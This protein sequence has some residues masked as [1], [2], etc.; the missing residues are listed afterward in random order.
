MTKQLM[1]NIDGAVYQYIT[2]LSKQE[3]VTKRK[4]LEDAITHYRRF[5]E[6]KKLDEAYKDMSQDEE[7]LKEMEDTA[8]Y[9]AH[10]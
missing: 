10:L 5:L 6:Q 1:T 3:K 7:Y 4:I 9:L 8:Q 2:H